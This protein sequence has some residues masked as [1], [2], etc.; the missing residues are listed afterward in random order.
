MSEKLPA[1][2]PGQVT[3]PATSGFLIFAGRVTSPGEKL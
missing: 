2:T 3:G 1:Q